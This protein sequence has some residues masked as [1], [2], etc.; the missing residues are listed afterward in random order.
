MWAG[1]RAHFERGLWTE[2][3]WAESRRP[4]PQGGSRGDAESWAA[5][6]RGSAGCSLS[7]ACSATSQG[8][9]WSARPGLSSSSLWA[10]PVHHTGSRQARVCIYG[11]SRPLGGAPDLSSPSSP[12]PPPS[13]L[14]GMFLGSRLRAGQGAC[15]GGLRAPPT[16]SRMPGEK[17]LLST[18]PLPLSLGALCLVAAGSRSSV[19]AAGCCGPDA[20]CSEQNCMLT[21]LPA[22]PMPVT[23]AP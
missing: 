10:A 16:L 5:E 4:P 8:S 14:P 13:S 6:G 3:D 2:P 18:H 19:R 1:S 20:A 12:F 7:L 17:G 23:Q 9:G 22:S 11:L 21:S 15:N